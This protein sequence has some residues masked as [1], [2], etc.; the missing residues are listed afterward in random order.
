MRT[1]LNLAVGIAMAAGL[2]SPGTAVIALD[3]LPGDLS[4]VEKRVE[5]W[6][7]KPSE[8]KFD[9]I[10]WATDIRSGLALAKKHSRPLFLFTHDGRMARGRC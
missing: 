7:P 1:K 2:G 4:W 10:G 3:A 6:K 5:E 8:R 9:L